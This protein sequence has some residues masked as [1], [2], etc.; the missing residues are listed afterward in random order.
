MP[1]D[2]SFVTVV[3]GLPRSGTSLMM[4]MLDMGGRPPLTD[5]V[6]AADPDNPRGY[7]EYE[8]VKQLPKGDHA[9]LPDARGRA[10]KVISALLEHLPDGYEYR[11]IFMRRRMEEVLASQREMLLRRGEP[12]EATS[13]APMTSLFEK[14]LNR[15][16]A[17]LAGRPNISRLDVDYARLMAEPAAQAERVAQFLGGGLDVERMVGAVDAGL[18]R[19]RA[20]GAGPA[21]IRG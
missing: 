14:H 6:R 12:T 9:W 1:A 18:Y 7:Y 13:D 11:V 17:S 10:V 3:S 8:R 2:A 19:Q 20:G 16:G 4:R 15:V 5:G 21:A